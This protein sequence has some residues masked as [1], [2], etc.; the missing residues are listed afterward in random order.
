MK[1]DNNFSPSMK[2]L[3]TV[4]TH[5]SVLTRLLAEYLIMFSFLLYEMRVPDECQS[6]YQL[7]V[8]WH[9]QVSLFES[10]FNKTHAISLFVKMVPL[11]K[12]WNLT[13]VNSVI[14]L[15]YMAMT[16]IITFFYV[17]RR[18]YW[19]RAKF[20]F[21]VF[22]GFTRFGISWTRF[23]YFWKMSVCL[24]VCLHVCDKNFVAKVTRELMHGI[25]W[26]FI[27]SIT[28]T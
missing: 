11:K 18:K 28:L 5:S 12:D 19:F 24:S 13:N 2:G 10:S 1:S 6:S 21:P 14:L 16:F 7:K 20:R 23:N 8:H 22:D 17:S 26:N 15:R 9:E 4:F 27:V 25:S 3:H